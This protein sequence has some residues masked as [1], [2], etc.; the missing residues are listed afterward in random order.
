MSTHNSRKNRSRF[1]CACGCGQRITPKNNKGLRG[2]RKFAPGCNIETM[3]RRNW[4]FLK[5]S[6]M[7]YGKPMVVYGGYRN[8]Q[9]DRLDAPT[10]A[11]A[12]S[13]SAFQTPGRTI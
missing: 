11:V 8:N 5:P 12:G 3:L 10:P 2:G 9:H 1:L 4:I 13:I 6:K 7:S